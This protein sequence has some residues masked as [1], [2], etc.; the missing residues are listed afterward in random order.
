METE[1]TDIGKVAITPRKDYKNEQNYEWLDVVTYDGASY[2]CIAEDGCTGIVPTNTDCWQLLADKG[3]FTEEDKEE[4]KKAVVEESKTEI[5]EHTDNKKTELNNYTTELE[6]SLE[7][8]LDTYKAEKEEQLDL[9]KATLEKEMA[10]KKDSLI[11]EIETAQ[12]GFD[13]NVEEKTNTFNS[14]VETK[15]TEFNN[16]SNAKTEE[17]NNNSTEK[18]NAFNS[19][20]EEKIA[21]YNEHVETLTSRIADLEEE[22]EDLFNAL[23]TEKI[24]GTELYIEDAKPCRIMNTEICGMYKQTTTIGANLLDISDMLFLNGLLEQNGLKATLNANGS[25]TING[26]ATNTTY[27]RKDIK[28][29]LEDGKY[30]FYNFN[31]QNQSNTTYYML[32][33][34]K[35]NT[36]NTA[37]DYYNA[38]GYQANTFEKDVE[39]FNE[40]F[41]CLFVFLKGFVANNLTLYPLISKNEQTFFETY[42]G[43]IASPSPNYP[44]AIEQI[45]NIE[46]IC[47][48][49][50]YIE[51]KLIDTTK[52]GI[53]TKINKDGSITFNGTATE[54]VQLN[55][56]SG[57]MVNVLP[58][59][60]AKKIK[61]GSYKLTGCPSGGS[62]STYKLDFWAGNNLYPRLCN[63]DT[64]TGAVI[65]LETNVTQ[66]LPRIV[67]YN[68]YT[69]NNLTFKPMLIKN[70]EV[71]INLEQGKRQTITLDLKGNELCAVS[72]TV[73]DKLLIDK[74]GNVALQK[75][76]NHYTFKKC[77][78]VNG[79]F[80]DKTQFGLNLS[81]CGKMVKQDEFYAISNCMLSCTVASGMG[82]FGTT[83]TG[84]VRVTILNSLLNVTA[85]DT[86]SVKLNAA[87]TLLQNLQQTPEIY[88]PAKLPE[89]IDL[90]QV[91]ELPK[92]FNGINNI[93][94]ETNLGNTEIEIEYVQDVKKLLEKQAEQQNARLDNIETLLSTT[95]TSALLLDNMQSDLE[96]EV[97]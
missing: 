88:Y 15:T 69:C 62:S 94:A 65:N 73:K 56:E 87:N 74:N 35:K 36:G 6:K 40:S 96:S 50:N 84:S 14:N 71:N 44:Q 29:F 64:G 16:N 3:H 51:N 53:T 31:N 46:F 33:Q 83:A 89:L 23:D 41:Y 19:N 93:W 52:Y 92:T 32:I 11:E 79:S 28:T 37:A 76:I 26:T 7:N 17:F 47:N 57:A 22:K 24:S 55:I 85:E 12:D 54:T 42:T 18:I 43:S 86:N 8:E 95:E 5:N 61:K 2:M 10:N 97:K 4:F 58:I 49:K 91:A 1:I 27:L 39:T 77:D 63:T 78:Y 34:G 75:N 80:T 59:A 20:A 38:R 21:D 66:V 67:I 13:S 9:H 82:F 70:T 90:G 72:N 48:N 68:G 25:I 45:K 30:Y 81:N 60:T